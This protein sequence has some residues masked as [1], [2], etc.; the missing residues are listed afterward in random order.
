MKILAIGAHPDDLEIG[1]F[2]TL[3]KLKDSGNDIEI[4]ITT[5]GG[6]KSFE[7]NRSRNWDDIT[8]EAKKSAGMLCAPIVFFDNPVLYH[9]T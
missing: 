6:Y 2:G 3:K 1:C 7:T 9:P 4:I 8:S 5:S